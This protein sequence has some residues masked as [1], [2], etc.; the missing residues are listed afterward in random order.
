MI[1]VEY[2]GKVKSDW[3]VLHYNPYVIYLCMT[4][5]EKSPLVRA[6]SFYGDRHYSL[7]EFP[8]IVE[9]VKSEKFESPFSICP[10]G[11]GDIAV[12]LNSSSDGHTA[13]YFW[14]RGNRTL[15]HTLALAN[16]LNSSPE[17]KKILFVG[18]KKS[19]N[20]IEDQDTVTDFLANRKDCI[21]L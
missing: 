21:P 10:A 18:F 20:P 1:F 3:L 15:E 2:E 19:V 5:L 6:V 17:V 16:T 13:D 8:A 12:W 11:Y 9:W 14:V 7:D 4:A